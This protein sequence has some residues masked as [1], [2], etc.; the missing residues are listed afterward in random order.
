MSVNDG[1]YSFKVYNYFMTINFRINQDYLIAHTL[2]SCKEHDFSS[3]EHKKDIVA[4]QDHAWELSKDLYNLIPERTDAE[5]ILRIG[6]F[7]KYTKMVGQL[8]DYVNKLKQS[9]EFKVIL[10]QT[11]KYRQ[12]CEREW[13]SN[14]GRISKI[15]QELTQFNLDKQVAVFITHPSQ[16]NGRSIGLDKIA[17]GHTEDWPN[18]TVVY[19][20]HEILHKYMDNT[21]LNHA[22]IE[23]I[24]DYELRRQ[25]GGPDYP[26]FTTGHE[27]LQKTE[28]IL[29]PHWKRYLSSKNKNFTNFQEKV[30]KLTDL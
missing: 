13:G 11:E 9:K 26:P 16:R 10:E 21:D 17:W 20:W 6:D 3:E 28:E 12:F 18:Y 15:I 23:L 25:L 27:R 7:E 24:T 22:L 4:F 30:E 8:D 5:T 14:Y 29:L 19:L 2:I 1:H